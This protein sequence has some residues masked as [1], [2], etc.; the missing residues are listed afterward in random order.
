VARARCRREEARTRVNDLLAGLH[1]ERH[2][3]RPG[4]YTFHLGRTFNRKVV[5]LKPVFRRLLDSVDDRTPASAIP[6]KLGV[7]SSR[8]AEACS[9][10]LAKLLKG[11]LIDVRQGAVEGERPAL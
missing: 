9:A 4:T 6:S 7:R 1:P 8:E 5:E 10:G 2:L 11:G 3:L